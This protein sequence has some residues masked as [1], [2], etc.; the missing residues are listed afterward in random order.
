MHNYLLAVLFALLSA[1]TIAWGTVVRH[2]IAEAAPVGGNAAI[3]S[4]MKRPLWWAG[5]STAIIAY[6]LQVVALG[7]GPL[8]VVQ[9]I[10]VMSLMFTLPLSARYD[11]R[12]ITFSE[13]TWAT[14]LTAAVTVLV[15]LGRPLPGI[16]HPPLER[17]FI[18]VGVGFLVLFAMD[19][20]ASR[21]IRREKA[22]ILGIVTG[23]IFGFVAVFSKAVADIFILH[24]FLGLL[25]NWE[26]YAL[27]I[28]ATLGT[29]VQ[30][31]SFNA[32]A[33][34]NSLPAMKS[35]EPVV[36]FSLGYLVLGEKFSATD[37][38]WLWMFL[39]LIAMIFATVMLSRRGV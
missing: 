34:R 33:L 23:A 3:L 15:L 2:R 4:A 30:Q 1:L 7:F 24:G 8:L 12:R 10:L 29:I 9:P 35:A 17:W 6:F 36:A 22:L 25:S 11:G 32:G 37:L 5:M 16:T 20:Y 31:S 28:A 26:L 27:I 18:P 13:M 38:E 39:A 19:R 21:Q 14:V